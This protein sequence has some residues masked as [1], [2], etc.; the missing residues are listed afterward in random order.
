MHPWVLY[1]IYFSVGGL[2]T[3]AIALL[4]ASSRTG[5]AAT[6]GCLPVHYLTNVIICLLVAGTAATVSFS[7]TSIITNFTWIFSVVIFTWVLQSTGNAILAV[8]ACAL[9]SIVMAAMMNVIFGFS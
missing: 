8:A 5:L 2:A 4:N 9:S 6:V 3:L 1:F 7:K